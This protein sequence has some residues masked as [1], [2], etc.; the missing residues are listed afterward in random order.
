MKIFKRISSALLIMASFF[1]IGCNDS[2]SYS[3]LLTEEERAVN[4][5]LARNEVI[6]SPP[7]DSIFLEG[8]NAPF[9]KM[10]TDGSVYMRVVNAGDS[11]NRPKNGDRI[12]FT[13]MRQSIKDLSKGN[14][15]PWIGNDEDMNNALGSTSFFLGNLVLP[16][17]TQYGTGIQIPMEYLGYY[18][19]VELIIKS[20]KGFE[21]DVT[22]C[23]PYLY[24]VR[25]FPAIY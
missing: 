1:S 14:E 7:K 17:T 25:Y 11:E 6:V 15:A 3:E 22:Q 19:Q 9:Y 23:E 16:S 5:Y 20:T 8:D 13:F 10:Q 12:Y 4:W 18:S 21:T 2:K 24:K